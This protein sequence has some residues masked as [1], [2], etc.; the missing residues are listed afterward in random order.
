MRGAALVLGTL[1]VIATFVW[2]MYFVPLGC[3]MNTT[4]CR[5][6]FTVWSGLG[7]V[8]FWSPLLVATSAIVFGLSGS[9]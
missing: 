7:L 9:K 6:T 1:L 2:F 4:G 8:H 5:E 3:A